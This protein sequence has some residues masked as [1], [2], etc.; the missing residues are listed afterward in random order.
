MTLVFVL[1]QP[2]AP[3]PHPGIPITPRTGGAGPKL[4]RPHRP[5][6]WR[7]LA[8]QTRGQDEVAFV[9]GV[10]SRAKVESGAEV[11][12]EVEV[13]HGPGTGPRPGSLT[14][15]PV[16]ESE[17][18]RDPHGG[19]LRFLQQGSETVGDVDTGSL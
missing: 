14:R 10:G 13:T 7:L 18:I 12:R 6:R 17:A 1:A 3:R 5:A 19:P 8:S 4:F 2:P 11:G 9:G 16:L 15:V